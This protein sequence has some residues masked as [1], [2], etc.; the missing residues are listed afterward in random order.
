MTEIATL[1]GGKVKIEI[2]SWHRYWLLDAKGKRGARIPGTTSITGIKDKSAPLMWWAV[3]KAL[4]TLGYFN[5]KK[6]RENN[7]PAKAEE[8]VSKMRIELA[9]RLEQLRLMTPEQWKDALESARKK[10]NEK[11]KE[12]GNL[13]TAIHALAEQ[14]IRWKA[15][16]AGIFEPKVPDDE[17]LRNGFAAFLWAGEKHKI[18]FHNSEVKVYSKKHK[19]G[20]TMDADGEVT[21]C[22]DPACCGD[23]PQVAELAVIDFKTSNGLYDEMKMQVTGYKEAREEEL[24]MKYKSFWLMRFGKETKIDEHGVEFAEFELHRYSVDECPRHFAAFLG[25]RQLYVWH[26]ENEEKRKVAGG[27]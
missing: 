13:G 24:G 10:H 26:M 15:G 18:K 23:A 27:S 20:G 8:I 21:P 9:N 5:E 22:G 17:R 1:Y 25:A 19:Y 14:W 3:E 16:E 7:P 2:D 11:K 6:I 4:E 12:A